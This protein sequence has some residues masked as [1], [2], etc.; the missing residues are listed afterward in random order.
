M[1]SSLSAHH[2]LVSDNIADAAILSALHWK[3]L[4]GTKGFRVDFGGVVDT[5]AVG[6][7]KYFTLRTEEHKL[8]G[9]LGMM[10]LRPPYYGKVVAMDIFYFVMPEFRGTFGLCKLFKFAANTL[11]SMGV[12]QV[13]LS[14]PNHVD[15]SAVLKRAG[16]RKTGETFMFGE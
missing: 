13:T 8:V 9:H 7:F 1:T 11:Q 15:L 6:G 14:N 4:Y 2:E 10:V 3:E 5:E 12:Q 16:Y